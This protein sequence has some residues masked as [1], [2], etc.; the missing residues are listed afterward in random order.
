MDRAATAEITRRPGAE[1]VPSPPPAPEPTRPAV[2]DKPDRD[3][4]DQPRTRVETPQ[5]VATDAARQFRGLRF[6]L[7]VAVAIAVTVI[8]TAINVQSGRILDREGHGWSFRVLFGP[9]VL[10]GTNLQ[11]W[12]VVTEPGQLSDPDRY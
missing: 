2:A 5:T 11:G 10:S 1:P 7:G 3:H 8:L 4:V 6:A 9:D 12:R